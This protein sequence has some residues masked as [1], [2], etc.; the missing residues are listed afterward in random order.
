MNYGYNPMEEFKKRL[1]DLGKN[2]NKSLLK[3]KNSSF[4]GSDKKV[5]VVEQLD[6]VIRRCLL[7]ENLLDMDSAANDFKALYAREID[8]VRSA[9]QT[10]SAL[11]DMLL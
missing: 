7:L 11:D 1:Q 6:S 8:F 9:E 10:L 2:K 3:V 4:L 5:R